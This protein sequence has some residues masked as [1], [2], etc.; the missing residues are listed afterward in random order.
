M[1]S[2]CPTVFCLLLLPASALLVAQGYEPGNLTGIPTAA[3]LDRYYLAQARAEL[4]FL[5]GE[6]L[7]PKDAIRRLE[8]R[9]EGQ[10]MVSIL[11]DGL[12]L[13]HHARLM[14]R[15]TGET[16]WTKFAVDLADTLYRRY[17]LPS[18]A[19]I[20]RDRAPW[21]EPERGWRTIPWGVNFRGNEIL[22]TYRLLKN[23]LSPEQTAWWQAQLQKLGDFI[24]RNPL[25]GS[26]VFNAAIDICRLHWRLGQ[27]FGNEEWKRWALEAARFRIERD[28]DGEGWI[29]GESGGVSGVYQTV[30]ARHLGQFATQTQDPVIHEATKRVF[31]NA[32]AFASPNLS[33]NG[34]FGT[35]SA[36][37]RIVEPELILAAAALGEPQ[38]VYLT[39]RYGRLSWSSDPA[40]W[41]A[42]LSHRAEA[43]AH[44]TVHSFKGIDTTVLREGPWIVYLTNYAKSRWV[45][46]FSG[47]WHSGF[48]DWVFSGLHS[49]PT[50]DRSVTLKMGIAD[51][52]T[53]DW[54]GF[55][56]VRV[57]DAGGRQFDSQQRME[58]LRVSGGEGKVSAEWSEPLLGRRG[59]PGGQCDFRL[60]VAGSALDIAVRAKGLAGTATL[61]YHVMHRPT[62]SAMLWAGREVERI[63]EGKLPV[64]GGMGAYEGT[65]YKEPPDKFAIQ[66]DKAV[67]GFE[68][69]E[70]PKDATVTLGMVRDDGLHSGNLGGF[71]LRFE[72]PA[73]KDFTLS[74]RARK[75]N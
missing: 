73:G 57:T 52:D 41:K 71:R 5:E 20:E 47:L 30:G 6:R 48:N 27:E 42:A 49:L 28:I 55:P 10:K 51:T 8:R 9:R 68:V 16:R 74:L 17:V 72:V 15:L 53:T 44:A 2:L 29:T 1:I 45:R 38:A 11:S 54:A 14:G 23:D 32:V 25:V 75:I 43:P 66:I 64:T 60:T 13:A 56:H 36:G 7:D 37:I 65:T 21:I 50:T 19:F 63:A 12:R 46:G 35:R 33:W 69:L 3:D 18:G 39:R 34:N 70:A 4:E 24:H 59:E 61:D 67:L 58:G 26:L 22:D 62:S 31:R 40:L